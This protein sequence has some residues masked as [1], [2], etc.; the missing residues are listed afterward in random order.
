MRTE[1]RLGLMHCWA[2]DGGAQWLTLGSSTGQCVLFDLRYQLRLS[3]WC[4]ASRSRIHSMVPYRAPSVGGSGLPAPQCVLLGSGAGL[5]TGWELGH[6]PR[7]SLVL[8][9]AA[10]SDAAAEAAAAPAT[11][12]LSGAGLRFG[13]AGAW[14]GGARHAEPP[15]RAR[16]PAPAPAPAPPPHAGASTAAPPAIRAVLASADG[17]AV[18]SASDDM[19]LC[20][21]RLAPG[22]AARS[23]VVGGAPGAAD[24]RGAPLRSFDERLLQRG[25]N[26]CRLVHE[27]RSQHPTAAFGEGGGGAA[28][29]AA[30]T[31]PPPRTPRAQG[32]GA[33]ESGGSSEYRAAITSAIC[34][35]VPHAAGILLAGSLDGT[36]KVW[37]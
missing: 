17:G 14:A 22:E 36:V 23:F 35:T 6:A 12:C 11:V 30:G 2:S 24:A 9:P 25:G 34:S 27:L 29:T 28:A 7:C 18:V 19:H 37:R 21:W 33:A 4:C 8:Q 10:V 16:A 26:S 13:T 20:C 15:A 32:G 3:S 31:L 5:L 1:R